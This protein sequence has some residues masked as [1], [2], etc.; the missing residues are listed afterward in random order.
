MT[1]TPTLG[2][3][4]VHVVLSQDLDRVV[5]AVVASVADLAP[6]YASIPREQVL[7]EFAAIVRTTTRAFIEVLRSGEMPTEEDLEPMAVA[8]GLRA[9]EGLPLSDI[10]AAYHVGISLVLDDL[11]PRVTPEDGDSLT[12]VYKQLMGFLARVMQAAS[13]GYLAA[14]SESLREVHGAKQALLDAV[15]DGGDARSVAERVGIRLPSGYGVLTLQMGSHPDEESSSVE[16]DVATR[17][18]LRRLR[19]ALDI[20]HPDALAAMTGGSALVLLPI[21]DPDTAREP[22]ALLG[23]LTR[24]AGATVLAAW[25]PAWVDQVPEAIVIT[26]EVL[27]VAA[28]LGR[29]EGLV[30]L[31]DVALP[32]QLSRRTPATARLA[33]VLAP[34]QSHRDLLATLEALTRE[35]LNRRRTAK[36]LSVHL[37]TVTYRL[38]RVRELTGL[39]ASDPMDVQLLL[40][41]VTARRTLAAGASVASAP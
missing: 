32:Y 31:D 11:T 2:G 40:A 41:A 35:G 34:L 28:D 36:V 22:V 25:E 38:N 15:L 4:P 13:Q 37:N 23:A 1:S 18:K 5:A 26:A 6:A 21:A 8:A 27:E 33:A 14:S 39:D 12:V 24:A 19:R 17:R 16:T 3:R 9:E 29:T 20:A 30:R 10:L 7:S